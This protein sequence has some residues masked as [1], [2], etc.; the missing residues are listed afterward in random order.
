MVHAVGSH[1]FV[2]FRCFPSASYNEIPIFGNTVVA[3]VGFVH[4]LRLYKKQFHRIVSY[5]DTINPEKVGVDEK[6]LPE[7]R[8]VRYRHE[9]ERIAGTHVEIG[10]V[11]VP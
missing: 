7:R 2:C 5:I 9:L 1:L 10:N 4:L 6:T 11:C 3:V 8:I